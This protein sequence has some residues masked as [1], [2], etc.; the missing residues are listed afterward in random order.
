EGHAISEYSDDIEGWLDALR[1]A[2]EIARVEAGVIDRTR[3]FSWL[4]DRQLLLLPPAALDDA[5]QRFTADGMHRAV[6]ARRELLSVPSSD[7]ADLIRQDP[8]GLFDL[9]REALGGT[10]AGLNI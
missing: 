10:Q 8:L 3:D 4:A 7:V 1:K 2:P 5:I 6:A 9:M